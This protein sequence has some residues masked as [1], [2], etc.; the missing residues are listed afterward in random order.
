MPTEEQIEQVR[1]FLLQ[2]LGKIS[3]EVPDEVATLPRVARL[4]IERQWVDPDTGDLMATGI[5]HMTDGRK[6]THS[7]RLR[8]VMRDGVIQGY[9]L[10]TQ[11]EDGLPFGMTD[12]SP[13]ECDDQA[14]DDLAD[15]EYSH[16]R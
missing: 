7:G 11:A 15:G 12:C 8:P 13:S 14:D 10:S 2:Q 16:G 4:E 9:A 3:D 6:L 5:A 1:Q